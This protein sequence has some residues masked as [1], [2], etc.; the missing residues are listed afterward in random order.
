[1]RSVVKRPVYDGRLLCFR[2]SEALADGAA[3]Y[4]TSLDD[5]EEQ[6]AEDSRRRCG[7]VWLWVDRRC[8]ELIRS[9]HL[10]MV[11]DPSDVFQEVSASW[12]CQFMWQQAARRRRWVG[13]QFSRDGGVGAAVWSETAL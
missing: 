8:C 3:E 4:D 11:D 2:R 6:A 1:M 10:K 5:K 13:W 12:G 7:L 9:H